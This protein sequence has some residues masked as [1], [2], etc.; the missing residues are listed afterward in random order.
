[1]K[2]TDVKTFVMG[3]SWRNLVFVK[4]YTDDGI[5]GVGEATLQNL[6]EPVVAYIEAAK[7]KHVIGSDPFRIEDLWLRM[8]KDDFWRGGVITYTGL[9]AI[10]IA[11][12]DILGK[13]TGLPIY[14]LLGGR[15]CDKIKVYANGW[16][17]VE[18]SPDEFAKR[19]KL[20]KEM[21][22]LALKVDPFGA[23]HYE[24][25]RAEM[26]SS[27]E[28]VD[29]IR[30]EVGED[31]EIMIEAHGR[32]SPHT[33]IEA[34]KR[35][36]G[37]EPSWIEEPVPPDNIKA[38]MKVAKRI[39]IPIATGERA[40]TRYD[41]REL[42]ESNTVDIIQPDLIHAGGILETKKIAAM[43]DSY[44]TTVA[45]HNSNGPVCTAVAA[46]LDSCTP[47]FRIQ[48]TFDDFSEP[49]VRAAVRG[50]Y[51]IEDG[52]LIVPNAPGLG[53]DLDEQVVA[54]HPPRSVHFNLWKDNWQYRR[55]ALS[56]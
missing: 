54:D 50:A 39:K 40:Y 17:T 26:R 16:Y 14:N 41:F 22:Y 13:K 8:F 42:L 33:A 31:F 25:S 15:C 20:V 51:K 47:N 55:S 1:M 36:E 11:C 7:K 29:A 12:W 24:L 9:S 44:Y 3:T 10:E 32:F 21:G 48:E 53:I 18:R 38:L 2:I 28:L 56:N 4:V 30:T 43:A 23:G 6:E 49:F 27:V 5:V 45:P 34:A 35:L 46:Q 52:H 37:Y 19:A